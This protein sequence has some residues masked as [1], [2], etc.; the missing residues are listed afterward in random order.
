MALS[1]LGCRAMEDKAFQLGG[2]SASLRLTD[3]RD[4]LRLIIP[5]Q[6]SAHYID[7]GKCSI[8]NL[9]NVFV[10]TG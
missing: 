3:R 4:H 2:A 5:V 1:V 7:L 8:N 10:R 6:Q 9:V